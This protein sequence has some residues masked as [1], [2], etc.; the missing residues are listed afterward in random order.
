AAAPTAAA[1]PTAATAS[2]GAMAGAPKLAV[3]DGAELRVS[4]WGNP[5]EQKVNTDSFARF[6]AMYPNVK[7]K[8]EPQPDNFQT[9]IKADFAGST[10]PDVFY[11]DSSLMTAL[12]PNDLLLSLDSA[13]A[14]GGVKTG[15]Y[16]G[17]LVTLFQ[18]NGKTYALPKDQGS[19][20]LFINN[21]IAQ[22]GG[23]DPASLKT[24]DDVTAA[25]KKMTSGEGP[26]KI[27][28]MCSN[29]DSQ[30]GTAFI[31]QTGNPIIDNG[32]AVFNKD[33]AIKAVEWWYSFK[34][35][36]TGELFKE[37]G[38]GWCGEAF[39]KGKVGMVV[40]GGWMLP[41]LADPS[42][43]AQN[44]KYTA[45]PLPIPQGGKPA[46]LVFTNGWAA[47]AR[48]KYPKAAA[49]LV[50]FLTSA[51]NQKPI[52]ETGFALPTIK[53]LLTDP[54]FEKNP[55]AK[56]LAEAPSYGKVADLVFGG[57]AKKD[58]VLKPIG[59]AFEQIFSGGADVKSALDQ[60]AQAA[61]QVLSQ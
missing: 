5:S 35:D 56:V 32:K 13:M 28:G 12:A 51:A 21:D 3:E 36:G 57:P 7:I 16:V 50:L 6:N 55:N 29:A 53:S 8:Y 17:D 58:D 47:S 26:A 40:E 39:G 24:W 60:G 44:V 20:A 49:A 10:E 41:F 30:R 18:Q 1:E 34:K 37:L 38:A 43:G 2:G 54:Y 46:T 42:N 9:K 19:L 31:L 45:V 15:D 27:Y 48:T 25:A 33:D 22:K 52:L 61:D 14:E 11:L 59:D 4:S 23:V